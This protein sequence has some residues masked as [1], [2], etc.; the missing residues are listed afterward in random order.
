MESTEDSTV[1]TQ[2][3]F[4]SG[5]F[6][7]QE[8]EEELTNPGRFGKNL[9]DWIRQG[10]EQ[11]GIPVEEPSPE[12]W[13]WLLSLS[14]ESVPFTLGIGNEGDA[15]DRW[16]VWVEPQVGIFWRKKKA[17]AVRKTEVELRG[18]IQELLDSNQ[19]VTDVEWLRP[20]PG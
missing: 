2:V 20:T 6:Q 17:H 1:L 8:G 7:P 19:D 5:A 4:S 11:R 9:A 15:E 16:S 10:L 13:G 3:W 12:D 14:A 18:V